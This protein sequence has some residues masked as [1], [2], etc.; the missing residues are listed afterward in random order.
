MATRFKELYARKAFIALLAG[1]ALGGGVRAE[2]TD[3]QRLASLK[4]LS[5]GFDFNYPKSP[6]ALKSY[7]DEKRET[8]RYLVQTISFLSVGDNGQ[9][10]NQVTGLYYQ[11]KRPGRKPLVVVLPIWG[12]HTYPSRKITES[13][14]RYSKGGMNVLRLLGKD[15]LFDWDAMRSAPDEQ[16]LIAVA[17]RM[18]E[19]VRV[20]IVDIRRALDWLEKQPGIDAARIGL[21]GFSMGASVGGLIASHEPRIAAS[22]LA[23]GGANLNEMFATCFGRA[24]E[25][26]NVLL[27]RLGW[28][29]E[30]F[31]KKLEAPLYPIN[32][33]AYGGR[34]NPNRV[35]LFEAEYD[36]C[37]PESGRTAFWQALGEPERILWPYD[38]KMAFL[39]MS[40][41]GMNTMRRQIYDFLETTLLGD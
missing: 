4:P 28:T 24:Q 31:E 35:L 30:I 2:G 27:D 17:G 5:S 16:S 21:V 18:V 39:M 26:R 22:A 12:T 34:V 14:L 41:L 6:I 19:R 13:L 38:H 1:F 10:N 20:N 8:K 11:S 7:L 32:P 36:T 37:I 29:E 3:S 33:A 23:M 9:D 25:A 40:P 15:F